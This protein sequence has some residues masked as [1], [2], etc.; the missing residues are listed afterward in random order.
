MVA[1]VLETSHV[2]CCPN[3]VRGV[4][5]WSS[6]PR[7]LLAFGTSCSVVLY[8][9][10][11]RVVVTNLN[12]HT[13]RVNCIQWICKQDGSPS[14][15][16]VSGGSDNQV[17]HWEIEDNQLLKAVHLQGHEG[18]VYAVHAV[19]QRRTSD[20]ALCTLIVSAA[21]DSA[22][23]LWSKKGPEVMCL[24]TLNFGNGFALALCLSFL[25]NTDVPILACGN[26]DCRIH[27]FAQ[28]NDQFQKVLSLCGHEDWIR[29]VEWAAFGR[30]LFLASC[31]QD[32]LIRIW[33]LYIKSTS[34][35]TQDDDNI[36]LKENT[37]T[38]EN[39]S[40]KIAFAVTLETVL[41][42]HENWVNAVHWQPVFYKDG[43]LQ[44][45]VR[46]LS[47]SMDKTMILWAPDEE[48]G[49]WLEQVRVGEVGGN[50]LG[51]YDCQFNEDGS[52]IIAHAFH[53]ALHLW[54]Q[55]TVNPV[56]WH[57]IARPQIHGY[58]LKCLAMIN[59][60]QFV[61]G[62]DEKVLRVFSAPRNFVEN[63]CAIT[64][65]SLNHVLCNQDSDLPE[66]ATVPALGLSNKAVFQGDIAS[67]PSD[68][69]ELLTSTGFEYQQVAFQPSILTEPPTED[70]L[71]QNT[72]WPE[73]QKLYG[74]GYEIFCV[75][76]NSSKTLLASACKAA[77]K[78]HAAI[79]LWN[80]TSWKQVQNLVFHSLTVTQ[81]AFSPNEKFLLAV[82][83]D[84]TWSLWKKQDTISP[85]FEPVFSL[86]A[87]TNKI[88]S[89]HSRIIWSCD[90]SPDSK[91]FF[92]GS[93]DKKVVV[94]G[95]CDSTD[96][97]IEHNIGPCSSVLDVG[98]AV[99][100]VSVCP[101][102]HPSQ[103]YVVAVGLECGKI[104]LYTWKKT[105]QVP[106][107][108]DW[109]HCVETSQSQSHTLAIRKLCWKNCSGK[110]EQ[111]EAE[112]AEWL[113]FASCGEDHT[114]KIHR[115]NKC[116]L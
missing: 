104:C 55:N 18:P 53:G 4:L 98:G 34:L 80:T 68:E 60:F 73:V 82:S 88:T 79:I 65:Q 14:T 3:R 15:E 6:G 70:H 69:E 113:H 36:R 92:T 84:R 62:A 33:K 102:L 64:G 59:R 71:L 61:S 12:G 101:V 66:G 105:D 115:V 1:P 44:Q 26:D 54:K 49:V 57:E 106:E 20:P 89:V 77:K 30:D 23:R 94:W 24:Q 41:A 5:N 100:A 38:I 39:E 107:I 109:T 96:D 74:H 72:L 103:R 91:Y 95:E 112:G 99:T 32:C 8:D 45:P 11:K 86:F 16:L 75:T 63:F 93:R 27:I 29:G 7:G 97:C 25:P 83:R 21:A 31:S 37:F 58:D 52:M 48:S 108:N 46:L 116:A 114:V 78:E 111:K 47:A 28:Q 85:E 22:V 13:A 10:L 56:T 76:C 50:T 67:Q 19:Y 40:V 35:E 9:P 51:F 110:T 87:F 42:G 81:M 2:F 43:V 90:W 17:I